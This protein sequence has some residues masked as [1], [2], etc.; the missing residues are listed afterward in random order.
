VI[1][2]FFESTT[3]KFDITKRFHLTFL[4]SILEVDFKVLL[5]LFTSAEFLLLVVRFN[6]SIN[7][8]VDQ[9]ESKA[10]QFFF[11]STKVDFGVLKSKLL[12]QFIRRSNSFCNY[13]LSF[14]SEI[15][16]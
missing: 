1:L 16:C 13:C 7:R 14:H 3:K 5:F 12:F 15:V 6:Y 9:V 4:F 10:I 2:L 11:V 8:I